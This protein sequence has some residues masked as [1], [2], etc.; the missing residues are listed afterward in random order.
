[1]PEGGLD[2][3]LM[4]LSDDQFL[5]VT[6]AA[7]EWDQPSPCRNYLYSVPTDRWQE[8]A[9]MTHQ[10]SA[11]SVIGLP[12][13]RV[14]VA[15]GGAPRWALSKSVSP[16]STEIYDPGHQRWFLAG[17]LDMPIADSVAVST[18]LGRS[19]LFGGSVLQPDKYNV[20]QR[21][22]TEILEFNFGT[23]EWSRAGQLAATRWGHTATLLLD[24]SILV[25]GGVERTR[26]LVDPTVERIV[27]AG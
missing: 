14:L 7:D 17:D 15:G 27:I 13:G 4:H 18:R 9:L 3:E 24:N 11:P 21:G 19:Y 6:S 23:K 20:Q 26:A 16:V 1:M 8:A 12:D 2:I 10:R 25:V 5:A 22:L